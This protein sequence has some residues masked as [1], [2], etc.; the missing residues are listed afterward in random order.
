MD[1]IK[2]QLQKL[3]TLLKQYV[4]LICIVIFGSMYGFLIYTSGKLAERTP[5]EAKVSEQFQ[6]SSRPRL[7]ESVAQKLIELQDQNIEVKTLFEE[8]R[9]NP[10]AE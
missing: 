1:R 2:P 7:D 10:F 4:V 9:Q 3:T 5:S 6:G 8:A